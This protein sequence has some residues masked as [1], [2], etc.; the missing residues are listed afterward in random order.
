M[1]EE[2]RWSSERETLLREIAALRLRIDALEGEGTP[3]ADAVEAVLVA[4]KERRLI[5]GGEK[6]ILEE[7]EVMRMPEEEVGEKETVK[8]KRKT[9]RMGSEGDDVREMQVFV[10]LHFL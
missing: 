10:I 1:R 8:E 2:R 9:L 5:A 7:A 3:L 4:A 6:V